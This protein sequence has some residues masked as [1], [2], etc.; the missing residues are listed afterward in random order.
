MD[1]FIRCARERL[2]EVTEKGRGIQ[3]GKERI[4][5]MPAVCQVLVL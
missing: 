2:E 5:R 4:L 1:S 3:K